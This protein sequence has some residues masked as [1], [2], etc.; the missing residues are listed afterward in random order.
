MNRKSINAWIIIL[1]F[2]L[3]G[4]TANEKK[5][6]EIVEAD[7]QLPETLA[8]NQE[9]DLKVK[10]TQG[11]DSVEDADEVTFEIWKANEKEKAVFINARHDKN[12]IYS[13]QSSFKTDGVY[14]IQ[15]HVTARDMHVMPKLQVAVGNVTEEE[16]KAAKEAG[17]KEKSAEITGKHH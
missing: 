13:A 5:T 3:T 6:P 12:G 8:S 9:I 10:L 17:E 4:C 2:F 15:T 14:F 11:N 1:I 16:L 7:I